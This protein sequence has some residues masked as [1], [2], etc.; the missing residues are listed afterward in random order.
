[1]LNSIKIACIRTCCIPGDRLLYSYAVT[2]YLTRR[3]LRCGYAEGGIKK[4]RKKFFQ[5]SA[6]SA[7]EITKPCAWAK[8][9]GVKKC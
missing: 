6:G 5:N 1:M 2:S 4:I 3:L 9:F 7:G 8:Q